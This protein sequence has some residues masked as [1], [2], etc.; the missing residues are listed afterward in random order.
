M[1]K[2]AHGCCTN[3]Y[4]GL[5][6]PSRIDM[7]AFAASPDCRS[8]SY[9]PD[10]LLALTVIEHTYALYQFWGLGDN[11]YQ[12]PQWW[13]ETVDFFYRCRSNKPET[14]KDAP[15][16]KRVSFNDKGKM[17]VN[18]EKI[19]DETLKLQCFDVYYEQSGMAKQMPMDLWLEGIRKIRIQ[20]LRDN[21]EQMKTYREFCRRNHLE[22]KGGQLWLHLEDPG[23]TEA[24]V[25]PETPEQLDNFLLSCIG[26]RHRPTRPLRRRSEVLP[27]RSYSKL[28]P[29]SAGQQSF[30]YE[31]AAI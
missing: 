12:D 27:S 28:I 22:F 20:L 16:V 1:P 13:F 7:P 5:I 9:P 21:N 25:Q 11:G 31:G 8:G 29:T 10:Q 4:G 18:Y 30:V 6:N 3:P 14:W 24:L 15:P 2:E 17:V 19:P 26:N 23:E